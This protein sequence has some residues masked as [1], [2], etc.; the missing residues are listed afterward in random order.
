[1]KA[2]IPLPS[3][4]EFK[5]WV[6]KFASNYPFINIPITFPNQHWTEWGQTLMSVPGFKNTPTPL[7]KQYG[8]N[9][10][11]WAIL[12]INRIGETP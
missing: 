6:E 2:T 7:K 1:M 4:L 5:D 11:T 10:Q 8:E 3:N 9:W 12:M